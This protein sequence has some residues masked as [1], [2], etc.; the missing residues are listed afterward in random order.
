MPPTG[1]PEIDANVDKAKPKPPRW[2]HINTESRVDPKVK[3][4]ESVD[5]R[6]ELNK[7]D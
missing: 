7:I 3:W 2:K 6:K 4:D 1:N 5:W